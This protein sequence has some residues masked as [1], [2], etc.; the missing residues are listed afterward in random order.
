MSIS[1]TVFV[2]DTYCW[3]NKSFCKSRCIALHRYVSTWNSVRFVF[4][5]NQVQWVANIINNIQCFLFYH[6][7]EDGAKRLNIFTHYVLSF[8]HYFVESPRVVLFQR[9]KIAKLVVTQN[10]LYD[11]PVE[12]AQDV[13]AHPELSELPQEEQALIGF[14]QASVNVWG[15]AQ[16]IIDSC[17]EVLVSCHLANLL[18]LDDQRLDRFFLPSEVNNHLFSWWDSTPGNVHHTSS[19]SH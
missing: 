17:A 2:K 5:K 16:L 9:P 18:A 8:V 4:S 6:A 11:R 14:F 1:I 3:W 19:P 10:W 7:L 12:Q 13:A 15:P